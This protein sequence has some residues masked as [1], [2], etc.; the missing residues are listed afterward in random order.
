M[1]LRLP[2]SSKQTAD[3]TYL[4]AAFHRH[5][6]GAGALGVDVVGRCWR[7]DHAHCDGSCHVRLRGGV[8]ERIRT[9]LRSGSPSLDEQI[10]TLIWE[11]HARLDHADGDPNRLH[12]EEYESSWR[13][14]PGPE[15]DFQPPVFL[16]P[17]SNTADERPDS[18]LA[19]LAALNKHVHT[20]STH[21][22][23][24]SVSLSL[25]QRR[26]LDMLC[27]RRDMPTMY[28]RTTPDWFF[29]EKVNDQQVLASIEPDTRARVKSLMQYEYNLRQEWFAMHAVLVENARHERRACQIEMT[30]LN[31]A[32]SVEGITKI[33]GDIAESGIN[34]I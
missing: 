28:A 29:R 3:R 21:V 16:P 17:V 23:E 9:L 10:R 13:Y 19:R 22:R 11:T 30:A 18:P 34:D 7:C 15:I 1:P 2:C 33:V 32:L 20:A 4:R 25:E 8:D 5:M 31:K 14:L 6:S 12:E 26:V 27:Y 24:A